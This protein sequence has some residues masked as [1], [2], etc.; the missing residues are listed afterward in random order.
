MR[1]FFVKNGQFLGYEFDKVREDFVE[2][3][4]YPTVGIDTKCP[5]FVNFGAHPFRFDFKNIEHFT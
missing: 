3:G 5:I 2:S 4:L 1:I